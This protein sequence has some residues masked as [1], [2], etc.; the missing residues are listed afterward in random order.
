MTN[1]REFLG[2]SAGAILGAST[3]GH[4]RTVRRGSLTQTAPVTEGLPGQIAHAEGARL[5]SRSR[6]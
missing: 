5:V 2:L 3:I 6:S 1:R 4:A